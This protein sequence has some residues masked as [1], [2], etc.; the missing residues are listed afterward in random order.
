MF[1]NE[2]ADIVY[3]MTKKTLIA[4]FFC[5]A[6]AL[7]P[8]DAPEEEPS[9]PRGF[10]GVEIGLDLSELKAALSA[11]PYL[12]FRGDPDVSLLAREEELL[13]QSEGLGFVLRGICQLYNQRVYLVS[14]QLDSQRIDYFTMYSTLT[15]KYGD[16]DL[17]SPDEAVW[18]NAEL[19]LSL[20]R[21]LTIKYLDREVFAQIIESSKREE[22]LMEMEREV[23]LEGF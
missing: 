10:H 18:E 14:F 22:S 1:G 21:P 16:P 20:E 3:E 9:L 15:A 11:H 17:L 7:F 13:V 5:M 2:R 23:F 6:W 12:S 8:Q 19:R 4:A